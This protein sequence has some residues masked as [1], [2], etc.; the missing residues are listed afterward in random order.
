[1]CCSWNWGSLQYV[2]KSLLNTLWI[3]YPF[4]SSSWN[5]SW[6]MSFEI[7]KGPYLFWSSFFEGLFEWIFL[8]SNHILSSSFSPCRFYL[9]LSNCFF[10][11]SCVNS[12]NFVAFSQLLCNPIRNSSNFRNSICTIKLPFYKYHPKLS[13]NGVCSVAMYFLLLYWNSVATI[14]SVQSFCW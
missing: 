2:N 6:P 13:T 3:I 14:H 10:I 1:M 9:F 4:E 12:I 11:I 5:T 7:L 8:A